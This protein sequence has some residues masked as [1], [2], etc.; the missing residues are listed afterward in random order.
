MS[1]SAGFKPQRQTHHADGSLVRP[2]PTHS[3]K[4]DVDSC[5]SATFQSDSTLHSLSCLPAAKASNSASVTP[6]LAVGLRAMRILRVE[7]TSS[8]ASAAQSE[9][10]Q[11][12]HVSRVVAMVGHG[13]DMSGNA[14][15]KQLAAALEPVDDRSCQTRDTLHKPQPFSLP[16]LPA[17]HRTAI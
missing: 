2:L 17:A 5:V 8:N 10:Q 16:H 4:A 7:C 15:S 9:L 12:W 1:T 13:H 6:K 11:R 3:C 14:P